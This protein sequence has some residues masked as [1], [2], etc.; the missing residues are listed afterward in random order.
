MSWIT[1]PN[2]AGLFFGLIFT[3]TGAGAVLSPLPSLSSMFKFTPPTD[4]ASGQRFAT[5]LT[6]MYGMR[7]LYAGLVTLAVWYRGDR[8][9]LGWSLLFGGGVAAADSWASKNQLGKYDASHLVVT[10]ALIGIGGAL[11]S[12][13]A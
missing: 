2:F 12:G 3:S 5:S 7:D 6:R 1:L 4:A 11:I 10:A 13:S 9:L 8:E